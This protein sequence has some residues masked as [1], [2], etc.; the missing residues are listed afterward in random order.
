[1]GEVVQFRQAQ[2][3]LQT[4]LNLLVLN[5]QVTDVANRKVTKQLDV[6]T[7]DLIEEL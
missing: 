5:H 4:K 1:M 7:S 6:M 2:F 3:L